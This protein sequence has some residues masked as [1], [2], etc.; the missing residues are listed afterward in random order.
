MAAVTPLKLDTTN[1]IVIQFTTGD[2]LGAAF[3]GTGLTSYTAG[4][5]IYATGATT[6]VKLAIGSSGTV[7]TSTGSAPSWAAN[8]ATVDITATNDNAGTV[9]PG[10]PVY[11]KSNGAVDKAKADAVS[12]MRCIGLNTASVAAAGTATIRTGGLLTLTTGEWD[13]ITGGSGGLTKG[14]VYLV[15]AATAGLLV[16]TYTTTSGQF[17][18]PVGEGVSTTI[19]C[20][21]PSR[22]TTIIGI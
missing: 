22:S 11:M 20:L 5:I 10:A 14:A 15:S 12:T 1:G 4:D 7:L 17:W 18:V 6:L 8:P 16:T 9:A 2:F 21:F 13:A 19:M 3:G